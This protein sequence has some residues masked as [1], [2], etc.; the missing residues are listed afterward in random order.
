M[1]GHRF[2]DDGGHT[3]ETQEV[4]GVSNVC[5][6]EIN[7]K[8]RYG[9]ITPA[10]TKK[11]K[12]IWKQQVDIDEVYLNWISFSTGCSGGFGIQPGKLT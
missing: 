7:A 4:I 9:G 5:A 8:I 6:E 11:N 2:Q 1:V 3:A 12:I 10:P